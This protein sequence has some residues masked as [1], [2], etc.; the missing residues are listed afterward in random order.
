MGQR[1]SSQYENHAFF[2]NTSRNLIF[3]SQD[4]FFFGYTD[5]QRVV[6]TVFQIGTRLHGVFG[7][8]FFTRNENEISTQLSK[9]FAEFQSINMI[10]TP[11]LGS[12]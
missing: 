7:T 3:F 1:T 2:Y 8:L 11:F 4:V 10:W 6:T 9:F 12:V 5:Y